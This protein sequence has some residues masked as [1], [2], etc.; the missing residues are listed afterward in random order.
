[1]VAAQTWTFPFGPWRRASEAPIL[2]PQGTTWESAGTFNP[3]VLRARVSADHPTSSD[4]YRTK[5][6]I[7]YRAQ[8]A[9]GTSR[10]GYAESQ[11]G[12]HFTRRAEP[13]LSPETDYE[14]GGGVEDPRLQQRIRWDYPTRPI[15]FIGR[16]LPKNRSF[17]AAPESLSRASSNLARHPFLTGNS[18]VLVY[19]GAD[20]H[21]VYRT[22]IAVF[23]RKNPRK[24]LS[25]RDQP[26][27]TPEKRLGEDRASS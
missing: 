17:R 4:R 19:N 24:L 6:V 5:I 9:A 3:A 25:R 15:Q 23:D 16:K 26:V 27:L 13:V 8:D 22:G 1:M 2:S 7:L 10:F 14:R 12:I 18:I 11:D 21:L 20:D